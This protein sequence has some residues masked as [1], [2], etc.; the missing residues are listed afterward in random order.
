MR[1][2]L[3]IFRHFIFSSFGSISS[4]TLR[5][6]LFIYSINI[7]CLLTMCQVLVGTV[8]SFLLFLGESHSHIPH[9]PT[10]TH[11]PPH[12][13]HLTSLLPYEAEWKLKIEI[14]LYII[15]TSVCALRFRPTL[16]NSEVFKHGLRSMGKLLTKLFPCPENRLDILLLQCEEVGWALNADTGA[17]SA[18]SNYCGPC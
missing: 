3:F 4:F 9:P 7:S 5:H 1:H 11:P 8:M 6:L 18:P 13:H 14:K 17:G 16:V 2:L 12:T 15:Y 10:L